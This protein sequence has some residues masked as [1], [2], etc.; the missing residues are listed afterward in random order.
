MTLWLNET[1]VL[2]LLL[3]GD[4]DCNIELTGLITSDI[5]FSLKDFKEFEDISK[6][7]RSLSFN[8]IVPIPTRK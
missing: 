2:L 7:Q 3:I 1:D 5:Q 8:N 6:K 4:T